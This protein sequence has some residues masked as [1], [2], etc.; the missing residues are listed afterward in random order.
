MVVYHSLPV[1]LSGFAPSNGSP[2]EVAGRLLHQGEGRLDALH[3]LLTLRQG[4]LALRP[5]KTECEENLQ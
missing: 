4:A 5:G 1:N 3:V 2:T